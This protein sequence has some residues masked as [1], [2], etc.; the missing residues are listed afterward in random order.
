MSTDSANVKDCSSPSLRYLAVWYAVAAILQL[1]LAF[2]PFWNSDLRWWHL[3]SRSEWLPAAVLVTVFV[4]IATV[5]LVFGR[6]IRLQKLFLVASTAAVYSL[7]FLGFILLKTEYSR[8]ATLAMFACAIATI[9]VPYTIGKSRWRSLSLSTLI[10]AVLVVPVLLGQGLG[11]T[12]ESK[13]VP[14]AYMM[15]SAYYNLDVR[16]YASPK[17][18]VFGGG[19]ARLGNGYLLLT[20]EGRLY[21]FDLDKQKA[22]NFTLLPFEVPINGK[23]F[24]AAFGRPWGK[25]TPLPPVWEGAETGGFIRTEEFRTYGL[26]VQDRGSNVRLFVS[27]AYWLASGACWVERVSLLETTREALLQHAADAEWKTLYETKPCLPVQGPRRRHNMPFIGNFGGGRMQLMDQHTLLLTIGDFGFDGVNSD[28]VI[29]QD[30]AFSYGKTIAIDLTD[31]HASI[32]SSGHRNPQGLYIDPSGTIWSTEH[33]PQGGDELNRLVREGNYGWPYA[34]Y[35]T[36]YGSFSWS[37]GKPETEWQQRGYRD[38]VFTW[39]PSIGVSNLFGVEHALFERWRGDLL[40]GSLRAKT[41]FRAH[42]REGRVMYLEPLVIGSRIRDVI[43]G[44]DGRIILLTDDD[45]VVSLLP[46]ENSTG[47]ALFAEKC[48]GC[49]SVTAEVGSRIGPNL[50]GVIGRSVASLTDYPNYSSCMRR[51]GGSW[52][53]ERLNAFVLE[54]TAFCPGT[55]MDFAGV[56]DDTERAAI[57]QYLGT[58]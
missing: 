11:L 58:R 39:I 3:S 40:I 25:A 53:E 1:L 51:L 20:G 5:A 38:P 9:P 41:L 27:H 37:I 44:H 30:A 47:E 6:V 35:G 55:A 4:V 22:P 13:L 7:V 28:D 23:D 14:K 26:L 48:T 15:N 31:G 36:N 19:L 56:T 21:A 29:S 42:L 33:G 17:S 49:H 32:F 45:T 16:T 12:R 52:S 24:A 18:L 57:I 34:T 2:L 43:E 8:L 54:P 46:V 50:K 10:I